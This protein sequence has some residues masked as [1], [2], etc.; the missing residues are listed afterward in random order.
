M[1]AMQLFPDRSL[2]LTE[3]KRSV[4][5]NCDDEILGGSN[6]IDIPMVS[7]VIHTYFFDS[8]GHSFPD[9]RECAEAVYEIR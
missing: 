4:V 1:N 8:I 9:V 7:C 3:D 6:A 5:R 2:S